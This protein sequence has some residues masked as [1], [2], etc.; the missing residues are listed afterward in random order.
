MP[1]GWMPRAILRMDFSALV[2]PHLVRT[3]LVLLEPNNIPTKFSETEAAMC[4][5]DDA[6][7]LF[8]ANSVLMGRRAFPER[9]I[10]IFVLHEYEA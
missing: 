7:T 10:Q 3:K 4:A 1:R 9:L 8:A 5:Y 6:R 2:E